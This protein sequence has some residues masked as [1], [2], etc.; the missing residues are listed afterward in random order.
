MNAR[1]ISVSE[2]KM[3]RKMVEQLRDDELMSL[4]EAIEGAKRIFVGDAGRSLLSMKGF[5]MR[6]MQ[7]EHETYLVGEVTTPAIHE[8]DLLIVGSGSGK[9]EVTLAV[10]KK[11]RSHGA[12][13]A[14]LTQHPDSPIANEC[15][16]VVTVP[17]TPADDPSDDEIDRYGKTNQPGNYAEAALT[18]TLDGVVGE[19]MFRRGQDFRTV[20]K[21]HANL[22]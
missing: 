7:T 21:M 3:L 2:A 1:E 12:K 22:E 15:D 19:L 5:A 17:G 8:G 11:A 6:L 4:I 14:V 13:T 18:L 20:R 9:T 10:V 16:V